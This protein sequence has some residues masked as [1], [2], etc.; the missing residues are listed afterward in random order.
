M[1]KTFFLVGSVGALSLLLA[2][3]LDPKGYAVR[4]LCLILFAASTAQCWNVVGGLANQ[5]SLG[6]AAFFGIGAYTSTLMQIHLG[7]TP[8]VGLPAGMLLAALASALLSVPTMRLKGPYFALATLAF[9]ECARIVA[10]SAARLTGGPQGVSVPYKGDSL[11][12]LQWQHAGSYVTVFVALFV[13]VFCV[14]A[15]MSNG[16][17]GYLLRAVRE[18][19]DAAE[20][21]GIDTLRIKLIGGVVSAALMAACGS[22]FAQFVFFIDP[23]TVFSGSSVSIRVALIA[24]VGGVGTVFGPL[25]GALLIVPLEEVLNIWL[26]NRVA[27]IGPLVF[28]VVL[29][30][31]VILRPRGIASLFPNAAP[32]AGKNK[33]SGVDIP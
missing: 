17:T 20:V 2:Q 27:G 19:E 9:A 11:A 1:K 5:I 30:A 8:W 16:R 33:E 23:D 13:T 7:I 6:H 21:A 15:Y 14:F 32:K 18:N 12:M 25:M 24:I 4:V 3:F 26:S 29:I 10:N 31:V 28:G 22:V